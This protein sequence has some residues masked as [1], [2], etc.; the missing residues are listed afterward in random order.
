M[1]PS[2]FGSIFASLLALATASCDRGTPL[3]EDETVLP[4]PDLGIDSALDAQATSDATFAAAFQARTS[5]LPV[6]ARGTV[7][8]ILSDDVSGDRHQRWILTLAN[9]QTLLVAHNIDIAPRIPNLQVGKVCYAQG[10]YEGNDEGG[11][12]HWTHKDPS[13]S[14]PAGW[15]QYLGSR[16]Q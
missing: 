11:V 12:V 14:H 13:G 15:I 6:L 7:S 16:Y 5:D 4:T 1:S 2:R 9:R 8:R 3:P 10:I